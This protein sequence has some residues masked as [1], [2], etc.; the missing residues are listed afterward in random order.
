MEG[1][2]GAERGEGLLL[3]G[4]VGSGGPG[5][6]PEGLKEGGREGGREGRKR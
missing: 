6:E 5:E 4:G 3:C 1:E 2:R